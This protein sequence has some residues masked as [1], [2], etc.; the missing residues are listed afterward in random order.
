MV[1]EVMTCVHAS[2]DSDGTDYDSHAQMMTNSDEKC[3]ASAQKTD[4]AK[5]SCCLSCYEVK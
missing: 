5:A 1:V 4:L 2:L 3:E